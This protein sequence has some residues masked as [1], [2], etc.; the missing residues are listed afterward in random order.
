MRWKVDQRKKK[1]SCPTKPRGEVNEQ[2]GS[3]TKEIKIDLTEDKHDKKHMVAKFEKP[4]V[5]VDPEKGV[6]LQV[7]V[8]D[9]SNLSTLKGL[10]NIHFHFHGGGSK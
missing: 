6:D 3:K 9:L 7:P 8:S 1:E 5:N 4:Q 2:D 10:V